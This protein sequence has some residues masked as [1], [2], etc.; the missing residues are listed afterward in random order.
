MGTNSR[1]CTNNTSASISATWESS[2]SPVG[3]GL[4]VPVRAL[5]HALSA[6]DD[7]AVE[8][9]EVDFRAE[10]STDASPALELVGA[11]RAV[12][13]AAALV[14]VM[15]ARRT[16]RV[17]AGDR[18]AAQALRVAALTVRGASSPYTLLWALWWGRERGRTCY[19]NA[20]QI[21]HVLF[22]F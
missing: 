1:V 19:T 8:V 10:L 4:H 21:K 2:S 13:H 22:T 20:F 7:E 14:V 15:C 16:R 11:G 12:G 5:G 18:A 17:T 6:V 3:R 9:G